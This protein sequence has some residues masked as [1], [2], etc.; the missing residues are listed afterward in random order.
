MRLFIKNSCYFWGSITLLTLLCMCVAPNL[1]AQT[2]AKTELQKKRKQLYA[3]MDMAKDLL[4]NTRSEKEASLNSLILLEKKIQNRGQI[5]ANIAENIDLVEEHIAEIEFRIDSLQSALE[6]LKED[7]AKSVRSAYVNRSDYNK[8]LFL[9]S[10][11]SVNDAY[12]RIKYLDY[13]RQSRQ[14]QLLQINRTQDTLVLKLADLQQEK[15]EQS[16]LLSNRQI[17]R[18]TLEIEKGNKDLMLKQLKKKE[19]SIEAK[20]KEKRLALDDLNK[21]IKEMIAK[22]TAADTNKGSSSAGKPKKLDTSPESLKLSGEFAQ[23]KGKL[24]WP[25]E[26]GV[27]TAN[28]GNNPHPVLKNITTTNNGIDISTEA[29]SKVRALFDGKVTNIL[30]NPTFQWAVII[31]HGNYFTVYTNLGEV[32]VD[33][34]TDVKTKQ[35]IGTVY[36]NPDDDEAIIHLEVWESNNKL[37]P[38]QWLYR[39]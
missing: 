22:A 35:N 26:K 17:E 5:I 18:E 12:K 29:N 1:Q 33:K 10:A 15:N 39:K 9:F 30:F 2:K 14:N 28:F 7:Y 20:L 13:Y 6:L 36:Y 32:T 11:K 24:P 21:Q 34:N 27:I 16:Q 19:K 37:N 8:L 31:K 25:V 38:A 23:N 3:E 4:R